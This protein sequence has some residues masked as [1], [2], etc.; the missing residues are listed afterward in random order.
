MCSSDLNPSV[1]IMAVGPADGHVFQV[2]GDS[3]GATH[4]GRW[5]VGDDGAATLRLSVTGADG[6]RFDLPIRHEWTGPDRMRITLEL[7]Q[8]IVVE[9]VRKTE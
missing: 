9:M 8:P 7:P 6:N 3:R 4:A 2:G 1:A 5:T